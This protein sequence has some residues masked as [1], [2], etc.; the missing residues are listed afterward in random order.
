MKESQNKKKIS[1]VTKAILSLVVVLATTFFTFFLIGKWNSI[2]A[3]GVANESIRLANTQQQG[4]K[5]DTSLAKQKRPDGKPVG[6]VVYLTFDDG[7]SEFTGKFLDVLKEQHVASTFFMQGSNL[8][9]TAFQENVKRA[10]K[11]G[12]YIGAHSMTHNS[13]K[14]YKKGQFVTEMKETLA[15]IHNITGTTPKLVRPPYGSAPGLKGQDIRNKIVE[16]GIKVW[17]WTIDSNDWKLK[18]NP[19]Q[20]IENVKRTTTEDV[21]VVLMH[22]KLQTL[23]ALPEIIKFYK[24]KGYEFGVYNEADHFQLNF[25]KDQRL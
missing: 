2:P 19:Q 9:N 20:I 13:D 6:K 10:V 17:D 7:P 16:A 14:L 21:E 1:V 11:E 22:E 5:E 8:Q 24:E 18:G 25:Q 4:K 3:K 12:H 23:Q 15:L